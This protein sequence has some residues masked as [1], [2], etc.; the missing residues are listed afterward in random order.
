MTLDL[1]TVKLPSGFDPSR[2]QDA[3]QKKIAETHGDGFELDNIDMEALTATASR[4]RS[5]TEVTRTRT[6]DHFDVRLAK[7][8]QPSHGDKVAAKF[9]DQ[10][11]GFQM[12]TFEPFLGRAT[13]TRMSDDEVRCRGALGVAL[14][15]KPWDVGVRSTADGGFDITLPRQY[16]PSKHDE[17]LQEVATAVVGRPGWRCVCDPAA[18]S[19]TIIPGE[20][21][22]FPAAIDHPFDDA[23]ADP[24]RMPLGRALGPAG[25]ELGEEVV[26]DFTA[27]PHTQVSGT[28]G[29]G[30]TVC[31][32]DAIFHQLA[33]GCEL[34]IIDVPHKAIDFGWCK[35]YVRAGG[36]GCD[37][38]EAAVT[39]LSL[40]YEEGQ[41][42][43]RLLAEHGVVKV[44]ELPAAL[45][46]KPVFILVDEVTGLIQ[47]EEV[48]RGVP[49]EHPMVMEANQ[50]NLLRATVLNFLKKIAAEMRFV[51]FRLLLSSQVSSTTTGVPTSLRM[52]LS[53]K[54]LMGVNPTDN[55]RKLS[56][57][58]PTSVPKVPTNVRA[59]SRANRG[60]G[61]AEIE[62]VTPVVWKAYFADSDRLAAAL[63]QRGTP[64]TSS[65]APTAEQIARHTPSLDDDYAQPRPKGESTPSGKPLD[66][67]FGPALDP[68]TGE[69]L[70]GFAK[71]NA[72]RKELAAGAHPDGSAKST[73]GPPCCRDCGA[74]ID[75]ASGDCACP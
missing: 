4:Q 66:P 12:T 27:G 47:P 5:I 58:D 42:R 26:V 75:T 71:A 23:L 29:S 24:D 35:Q 73:P 59:D 20:P 25:D 8:T 33:T 22:T 30:K 68:D 51:D 52:N 34:V 57:S 2:H 56:L 49:K 21:A 15:V 74:A 39:A 7:G 40:V 13:L 11:P 69:P 32:N 44:S 65:P 10:Y 31:L 41:R 70:R 60:V 48:P 19:A 18:L 43:A 38:P 16:V 36:W 64:T 50:I 61:V 9:A 54:F 46:P 28:T 45:R 62:G 6:A 67:K 3:L 37:S 1:V 14:G 55:N 17:K 53:N 72:A 63:T